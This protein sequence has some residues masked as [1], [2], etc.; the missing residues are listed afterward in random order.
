MTIGYWTAAITT[1]FP[2]CGREYLISGARDA[3]A[4]LADKWPLTYGRKYQRALSACA[5]VFEGKLDPNLARAAF[6]EA[7][8]EA[9]VSVRPGHRLSS[10][11]QAATF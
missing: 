5:A 2:D 11:Q 6:I 8:R 7:A 3:A 10:S 1:H 4:I 9:G